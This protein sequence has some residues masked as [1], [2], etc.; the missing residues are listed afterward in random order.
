H[1]TSLLFLFQL[2]EDREIFKRRYVA[3][4]F[5]ACRK[6]AKQAAHDLTASRLRQRVAEAK[7]VRFR[8]RSDLLRYP[9]AQFFLQLI[10]RFVTHL[11]RHKRRDSL[12]LYL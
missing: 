8:E 2:C 5:A 9:A 1:S 11:Q 4:H 10:R 6:L 3:F 7:I 12:T